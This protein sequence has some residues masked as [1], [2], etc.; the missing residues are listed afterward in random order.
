M[1][2]AVLE[3]KSR[4]VSEIHEAKTTSEDISPARRAFLWGWGDER[5]SLDH[6]RVLDSTA[7]DIH[8]KRPAG[9][10][11]SGFLPLG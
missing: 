2:P 9:L 4:I 5:M 8:A 11:G 7:Y 6:L 10:V 1:E 3:A